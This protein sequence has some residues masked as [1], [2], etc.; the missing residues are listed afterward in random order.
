MYF[1][2]TNPRIVPFDRRRCWTVSQ[3]FLL[4]CSQ[5]T[6]PPPIAVPCRI[7]LLLVVYHGVVVVRY[8]L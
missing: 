3:S 4:L 2:V 6:G 1:L 7:V 5:T 8:N